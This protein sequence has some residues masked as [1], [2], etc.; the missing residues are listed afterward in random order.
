MFVVIRYSTEYDDSKEEDGVFGPFDTEKKA[1]IASRNLRLKANGLNYTFEIAELIEDE[2]LDEEL[3]SYT[4]WYFDTR[5]C[6]FW[7]SRNEVLL[8][9]FSSE[10]I[11]AEKDSTLTLNGELVHFKAL[12]CYTLQDELP[13]Q[14]IIEQALT[15]NHDLVQAVKIH[16]VKVQLELEQKQ[17]QEQIRLSEQIQ[18]FV[19]YFVIDNG[20]VLET[21]AAIAK[22][23][24]HP[25]DGLVKVHDQFY[26]EYIVSAFGRNKLRIMSTE[27]I[28]TQK[29]KALAEAIQKSKELM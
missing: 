27:Q 1:E 24:I 3:V 7:I 12:D 8:E 11:V 10:L 16:L 22:K 2:S 21:S 26:Y 14:E 9:N 28:Y 17:L 6:T 23:S 20:Q 4:E 29:A 15:I 18:F 25:D 13:S 5:S 19:Y